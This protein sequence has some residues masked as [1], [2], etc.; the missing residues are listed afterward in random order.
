MNRLL[1]RF[2]ERSRGQRIGAWWG[3]LFLVGGMFWFLFYADVR[4]RV[5]RLDERR[6]DLTAQIA[7][8]RG[9]AKNL[10]RYREEV[11][12]LDADLHVALLELPD[13][14]EIPDLLKSMSTLA[15]QSGLEEGLFRP[16]PEVYRDFYAEV[17]VSIALTGTFH[18]VAAFFAEVGKLSRIV[19]ISQIS[20]KEPA[21]AADA[22]RIK[23]ECTAT[24]FRYLDEAEIARRAEVVDDKKKRRR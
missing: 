14:K 6:G 24:T 21:V 3:S 4:E 1:V 9:L 16:M 13:K 10:E 2:M 15:N 5:V 22:V 19:N 7:K 11:R 20:V 8:E 12:Q 18:Q 17:P 23:A